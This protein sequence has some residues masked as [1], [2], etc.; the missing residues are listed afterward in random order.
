MNFNLPGII[1]QIK[2]LNIKSELIKLEKEYLARENGHITLALQSLG[3]LAPDERRKAGAELNQLKQ[4][5]L[6]NLKEQETVIDELEIENKIK[7]EKIDVTAPA[8]YNQWRQESGFLH[9]IS[10]TIKELSKILTEEG[11]AIFDGD[12]IEDD[13]YNFSYLNTPKFHPA[14]QMQDTIYVDGQTIDS[15]IRNSGHFHSDQFLMRTHTS[16]QQ[17][18]IAK[19]I[20]AQIDEEQG[21]PESSEYKFKFATLGKTYRNDNDATHSP[22]FHQLEVVSVSKDLYARDLMSMLFN[23]LKKFFDINDLQIKL[24]N[25]Y[26]PF[27]QPSWEID[28]WLP[29]K[30]KWVEVLGS[31]MIHPN[32]IKNMGLDNELIR[33]YAFGAGLERLCM[34][35]YDIEDLRP[36]FS[37]DVNWLGYQAKKI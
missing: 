11:F 32:V 33:G 31:G 9:P 35:K 25:S 27:T 28:L 26:F 30:Q 22:M 23:V 15:D 2:G 4:E 16:A 20:I 37:H 21:R 3:K 24:R 19:K 7:N 34:L 6:K 29:S 5:I 8:N 17:I 13:I 36:F 12:D 14:R 10:K 1:T 18:R